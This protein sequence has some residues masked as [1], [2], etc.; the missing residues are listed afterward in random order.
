M[1]LSRTILPRGVPWLLTAYPPVM[2]SQSQLTFSPSLLTYM[3]FLV[4]LLTSSLCTSIACSPCFTSPLLHLH[5]HLLSPACL[6][7]SHAMCSLGSRT[8]YLNCVFRL[9]KSE[10]VLSCEPWNSGDRLPTLS[11]F[12]FA[13]QISKGAS[14]L[15][16]TFHTWITSKVWSVQSVMDIYFYMPGHQWIFDLV[17]WAN[18]GWEYP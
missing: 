4:L 3:G 9:W 18:F 7:V 11:L 13:L 6:S 14:D 16:W 1:S 17:P 8:W 2:G 5:L 10:E 12:G 15:F